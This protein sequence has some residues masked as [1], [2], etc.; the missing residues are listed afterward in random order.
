[1]NM[2]IFSMSI[3]IFKERILKQVLQINKKQVFNVTTTTCH[4]YYMLIVDSHEV[5]TQCLTRTFDAIT[6]VRYILSL[7]ISQLTVDFHFR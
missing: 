2:N 1:M 7:D 3:L 5:C 4:N 6:S